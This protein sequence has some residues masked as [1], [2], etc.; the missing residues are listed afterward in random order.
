MLNLTSRL[1][2]SIRDIPDEADW[3]DQSPQ[4]SRSDLTSTDILPDVEDALALQKRALLF[5]QQFLV[6]NFDDLHE[7]QSLT[8]ATHSSEL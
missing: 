7:L 6:S 8:L 2:I 3:S 4:A 1:A 5:L